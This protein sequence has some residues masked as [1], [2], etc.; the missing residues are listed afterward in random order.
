MTDDEL[1]R[2]TLNDDEYDKLRG[3]LMR[4]AARKAEIDKY[5]TYIEQLSDEEIT[6][7]VIGTVSE[8]R[9]MEYFRGGQDELCSAIQK[10][11]NRIKLKRSN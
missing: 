10:L 6:S 2:C 11:L 7:R 8:E 3:M 4:V 1:A 9:W 5:P